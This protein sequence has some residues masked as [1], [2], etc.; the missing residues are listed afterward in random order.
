MNC[1]AVYLLELES[2]LQ[3]PSRL[4]PKDT[5]FSAQFHFPPISSLS[6]FPGEPKTRAYEKATRIAPANALPSVTGSKLFSQIACGSKRPRE[7]RGLPDV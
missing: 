7:V 6:F 5:N 4:L 1:N 2:A 3:A